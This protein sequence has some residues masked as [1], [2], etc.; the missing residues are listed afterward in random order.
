[1]PHGI[2]T[3]TQKSRPLTRTK[4]KSYNGIKA[5]LPLHMIIMP[6]VLFTLIFS[7]IPMYGIVLAFQNYLP[8]HSIF[9]Q[10]WVGLRYFKRL[11]QMDD[12]YEI[13]RN[14][15]VISIL[16]I[17][18]LL[19]FSLI[20]ALLLNEIKSRK[21]RGTYQSML[22]FPHFLSWIIL[23]E[24]VK[25]VFADNGMVNY[26]LQKIGIDP[27]FF[28]GESTWFYVILFVSNLWQEAGFTAIIYT[29]AISGVDESLYEAA[30]M[31][32]ANRWQQAWHIT[33]K[34]IMPFV[35][36]LGILNLGNILNAGFDQVFNLYNGAVMGSADIIDTY[37]YRVGLMESQYSFGT[38]IG[39]FKSV[40]GFVLI[41][42]SYLLADKVAGY[43]I[44]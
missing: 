32:G 14:T 20:L 42:L 29:A 8:T 36:L 24:L 16:K 28:L 23:G 19:V 9:D 33:V 26:V 30:K 38:A 31:D 13:L 18:T 4:K 39:L 41:G 12:F 11:F 2:G 35:V 37:V 40:I 3:I 27:I 22:I 7:F 44:F 5:F 6:G 43:R 17:V 34:L 15:L 10:K 25:S 21:L 1:M